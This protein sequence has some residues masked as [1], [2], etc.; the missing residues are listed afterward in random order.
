MSHPLLL[1]NGGEKKN[2]KAY[3]ELVL[4]CNSGLQLGTAV[5][6]AL[7]RRTCLGQTRIQLGVGHL[8]VVG[9]EGGECDGV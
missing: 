2:N 6:V 4:G 7:G 9:G 3:L 1:N 8:T 5:T